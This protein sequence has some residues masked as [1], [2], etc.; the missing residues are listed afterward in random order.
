MKIILPTLIGSYTEGSA[1]A[2][3][4]RGHGMRVMSMSPEDA[5]HAP[6]QG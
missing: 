3:E 1:K 6:K 5:H 4:R 2:P